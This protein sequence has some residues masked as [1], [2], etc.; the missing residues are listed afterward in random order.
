MPPAAPATLAILVKGILLG[1]GAAVPIGPVNVQLARQ[2][3]RRGFLAGFA[4]GCGAVTVDVLYAVLANVGVQRLVRSAAVEWTLRVGGIALLTHLA[5]ACLRGEREAWS[6][7]LVT[8]GAAPA[9]NPGAGPG[10]AYATGVLMT[11]LNPMTLAFWFVAVPAL[12]GPVAAGVGPQLPLVCAG[13]FIG[14][15]SWVVLFAGVLALAGRFRRNWWL[16]AA[17]AAG[18]AALLV[19]AAAAL[20]SSIRSLL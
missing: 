11:L 5:L 13:V 16:A 20:L 4:L 2:A 8:T 17:D 7:D 19:F 12:A 1:L 10:R 14:T 6:A 3:L 18:G 15:I 9:T